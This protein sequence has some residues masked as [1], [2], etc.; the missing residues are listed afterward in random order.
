MDNTNALSGYYL[1]IQKEKD[2]NLG[3]SLEVGIDLKRLGK[4]PLEYYLNI[5]YACMKFS[6]YLLQ[7]QTWIYLN[8]HLTKKWHNTSILLYLNVSCSIKLLILKLK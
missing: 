4:E 8:D 1:Y 3:G 7:K 2:T 6:N 5:L